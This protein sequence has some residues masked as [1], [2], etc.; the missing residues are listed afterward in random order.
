MSLPLYMDHH[1]N[2]AIT[3]GLRQRGVDVRTAWED[4]HSRQADDELLARATELGR[5]LFTFD[6]D[7]LEI[8]AE[9][10]TT[11]R[12]FSGLIF[13]RSRGVSIGE[14]IRDLELVVQTLSA[15]EIENTVVWIPL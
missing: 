8:A 3:A 12:R 9:W 6:H 10:Q 14:T 15:T 4:G 11:G 13:A 2:A 7:L 1:V 5:I